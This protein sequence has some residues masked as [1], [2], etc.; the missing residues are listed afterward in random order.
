M[1]ESEND[2]E[3]LRS[4]IKSLKAA[5]ERT[6]DAERQVQRLERDLEAAKKVASA[7]MEAGMVVGSYLLVASCTVQVVQCKLYCA[8]LWWPAG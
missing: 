8:V 1:K 4:Q 6:H 3:E 5:A 2:N 7:E